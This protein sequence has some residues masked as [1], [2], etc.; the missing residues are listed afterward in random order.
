[1]QVL[2][3]EEGGRTSPFRAQYRP[4]HNFGDSENRHFYIGQV[5]VPEGESVAPGE[6]RELAITFLAVVG[7]AE[8]LKPGRRWRIQ[9]GAKLVALAEVLAVQ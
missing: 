9:E 6:T 4:N 5:E 7:V 3:T 2:S 8:K 1:M